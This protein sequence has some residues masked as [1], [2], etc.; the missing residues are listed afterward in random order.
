MEQISDRPLKDN[1]ADFL[2]LK[3]KYPD[4]PIISSI[5][6]FSNDEWAYLAKAARNTARTCWNSTFPAPT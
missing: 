1:L 6:G 3:K 2:Y 5:M 4:H